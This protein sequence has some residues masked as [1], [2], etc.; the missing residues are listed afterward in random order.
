MEICSSNSDNVA[1]S[2]VS[3]DELEVAVFETRLS[4]DEITDFEANGDNIAGFEASSDEIAGLE[5]RSD[6]IADS[7]ASNDEIVSPWRAA[8]RS[9]TP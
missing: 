5:V 7:E 8:M 6:E 4:S 3:S 2:D 9:L 1:D